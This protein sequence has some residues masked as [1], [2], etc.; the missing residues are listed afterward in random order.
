[1]VYSGRNRF[2]PLPCTRGRGDG[3]EGETPYTPAHFFRLWRD[4]PEKSRSC[5]YGRTCSERTITS[6]WTT[7]RSSAVKSVTRAT[8]TICLPHTSA[9][10]STPP[11]LVVVALGLRVTDMR[12]AWVAAR[13]QPRA[14][15]CGNG[16]DCVPS[17]VPDSRNSNLWVKCPLI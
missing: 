8:Q 5:S 10:T 2:S 1:M 4:P 12:T 11:M 14:G 13:R 16:N 15:T 17:C 6:A 7:T 9:C 3:G